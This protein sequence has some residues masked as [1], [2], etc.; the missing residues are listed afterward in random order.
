MSEQVPAR[1]TEVRQPTTSIDELTYPLYIPH[2]GGA[3]IA[4]EN[5][6]DALRAAVELG[7]KLVEVDCSRLRDG[8]LMVMHDETPDRTSNLRGSPDRL[9]TQAV[10]RGRVNAGD[11]FAS[12]WPSDLVIPS[13][14]DVL[15]E[16]GNHI[17]VLIEAK[18]AGSGAAAVDLALRSEL[19]HTVIVQ[20]FHRDELDAAI[21]ERLPAGLVHETGDVDAAGLRAEGVDYLA[22]YRDAPPEKVTAAVAAGLD[23]FVYGV[24]R[25]H[26][27]DRLAALGVDGFITDDPVYVSRRLPPF[28]SDPYVAQ[29]YWNG[30]LPSRE[31]ARGTFTPPDWWG[32]GP[33]WAS[34]SAA[35][36]HPGGYEGALQGWACPVAMPA[37][38]DPDGSRAAIGFDAVFDA[39]RDGDTSRWASIFFG[40][41]DDRPFRDRGA[42]PDA[43]HGYHALLRADGELA[44]YRVDAGEAVLLAA[45]RTPPLSLGRTV[46]RLEVRVSPGD[47]AVAR[48]DAGPDACVSAGDTAHRGGYFHLGRDGAA[49]RFRDVV[50]R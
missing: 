47:V 36:G 44:L 30:C 17:C 1:L 10:L 23:V 49:I 21:K 37:P 33:D 26:D 4:P 16:V 35:D 42:G 28:A 25:R 24:D 7:F 11:W 50:I 13:L 20:S 9:L 8:G 5:T 32:Y 41:P 18:N 3:N 48:T 2:R 34:A 6:I 12:S 40:A 27:H 45:A 19:A 43:P 38:G 15:R 46:A 29:T 31:G 14:S 39:V 22:V